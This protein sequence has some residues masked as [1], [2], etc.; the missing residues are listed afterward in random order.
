MFTSVFSLPDGLYIKHVDKVKLSAGRGNY[1]DY[2]FD[3]DTAESKTG[4]TPL[5]YGWCN[6]HRAPERFCFAD[7]NDLELSDPKTGRSIKASMI[8]LN[9]MQMGPDLRGLHSSPYIHLEQLSGRA[10]VVVWEKL[11]DENSLLLTEIAY[12]NKHARKRA[13]TALH[14]ALDERRVWRNSSYLIKGVRYEP[15]KQNNGCSVVRRDVSDLNVSGQAYQAGTLYLDDPDLEDTPFAKRPTFPCM[16]YPSLLEHQRV[17]SDN[18]VG[19]QSWAR[20]MSQADG[21]E[22]SRAVCG[23]KME[24]FERTQYEDLAA[25]RYRRQ[26]NS[27]AEISRSERLRPLSEVLQSLPEMLQSLS[28]MF[29]EMESRRLYDKVTSVE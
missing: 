25:E 6:M 29:Q 12:L 9:S 26:L 28:E 11:E 21:T 2:Q 8:D 18:D 17:T 15:Q 5:P 20:S 10:I 23:V 1:K 19:C 14:T 24:L 4:S 3:A 7:S 27:D 22:L 13:T 16:R